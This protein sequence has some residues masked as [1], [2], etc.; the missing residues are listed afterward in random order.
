MRYVLE[1][2][3]ICN[4][5]SKQEIRRK[6]GYMI[7]DRKVIEDMMNQNKYELAKD[8]LKVWKKLNW[9]ATD[10]ERLT[11]RYRLNGKYVAMIFIDEKVFQELRRLNRLGDD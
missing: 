2:V 8:K 1:F 9:I 10:E 5:L 7:V 3:A 6:K 11:K 4:F